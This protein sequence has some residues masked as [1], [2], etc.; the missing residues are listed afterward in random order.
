MRA[1]RAVVGG[2]F[3]DGTG[4]ASPMSYRRHMASHRADGGLSPR[5]E[6]SYTQKYSSKSRCL[7]EI[8][9]KDVFEC[10]ILHPI[11]L[12]IITSLTSIFWDT[13]TILKTM[14]TK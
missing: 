6:K 8:L 12:R 1:T 4:F 3:L 10:Q 9:R 5:I 11:L 2:L 13:K 14:P 7:K